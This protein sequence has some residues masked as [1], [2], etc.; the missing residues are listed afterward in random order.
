MT[1]ES[2]KMPR[3]TVL[4]ILSVLPLLNSDVDSTINW[5]DQFLNNGYENLNPGNQVDLFINGNNQRFEVQYNPNIPC[6]SQLKFKQAGNKPIFEEFNPNHPPQ[7]REYGEMLSN[8]IFPIKI[9]QVLKD[10]Q[11]PQVFMY[12]TADEQIYFPLK[13]NK[14]RALALENDNQTWAISAIVKPF[15]YFGDQ[16][17][18]PAYERVPSKL[19]ILWR[20]I[21]S[22]RFPFLDIYDDFGLGWAIVKPTFAEK[23]PAKLTVLGYVRDPRVFELAK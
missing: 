7:K 9:A 18:A 15:N 12:P 14:D 11:I 10:L 20:A 22:K 8:Y 23:T 13:N 2:P 1:I 6:A 5:L 19:K 3:R 4:K 17:I 16:T 21:F